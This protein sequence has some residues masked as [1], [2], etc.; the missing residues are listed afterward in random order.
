MHHGRNL[1]V[2]RSSAGGRRDFDLAQLMVARR[3]PKLLRV[4]MGGRGTR[5]AR[6]SDG[7]LRVRLRFPA[8]VDGLRV[9]LNGRGVTARLRRGA[10][11]AT[12][13]LS[14]D[15]GLRF[16]R[17][18]LK[19]VAWTDTGRWDGARATLAVDRRRPLAAAGP[20]SPHR[21]RCHAAA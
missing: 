18:R 2:V 4:A 5:S 11:V 14:A 13:S 17:N 6:A 16:G 21:C 1:L 7:S 19:A 10:R 3:D 8:R 12:A 9:R 20:I 15:A